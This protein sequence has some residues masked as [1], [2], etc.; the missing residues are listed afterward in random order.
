MRA[1]I[2]VQSRDN[3][4]FA[5]VTVTALY[6][7]ERNSDHGSSYMHYSMVLNL[8]NIGFPITIGQIKK[9]NGASKQFIH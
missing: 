6:P 4:R 7:A 5:W 9:K 2:N 3:T 1:T 8:S